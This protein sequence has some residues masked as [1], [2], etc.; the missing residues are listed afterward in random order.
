MA[1]RR[2]RIGPIG[3]VAAGLLLCSLSVRAQSSRDYTLEEHTLN[4]GGTASSQ[5]SAAYRLSLTSLGES[6]LSEG[7]SGAGHRSDQ[8]FVIRYRPPG[9]VHQLEFLDGT[10]LRWNGEPSAGTFSVYRDA[11]GSWVNDDYGDCIRSDLATNQWSDVVD[12]PVG[13]GRFYLVTVRNRLTEEGTLG[14]G[15]GKSRPNQNPCP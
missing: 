5:A 13:T 9:E 12:P 14:A 2:T 6:G 7:L 11:L 15:T 3:A 8:G 1:G 4:S 10:T